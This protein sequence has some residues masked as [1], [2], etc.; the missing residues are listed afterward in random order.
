MQ[1]ID[2]SGLGSVLFGLALVVVGFI[3]PPVTDPQLKWIFG[4][5]AIIAFAIGTI[6]IVRRWP[7]TPSAGAS[8]QSGGT[9]VSQEQGSGSQ[10]AQTG[11]NAI[12]QHGERNVVVGTGGTYK[13]SRSEDTQKG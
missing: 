4:V 3:F 7:E 6:F 9:K 10:I 8:E 12:A 1:K 5:L 13:R 2:W 11:D